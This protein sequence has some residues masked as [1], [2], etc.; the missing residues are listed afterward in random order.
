MTLLR[1]GPQASAGLYAFER[2][3]VTHEA[4]STR[5]RGSVG[6]RWYM[7]PATRSSV[8]VMGRDN[9]LRSFAIVSTRAARVVRPCSKRGFVGLAEKMLEFCPELG[10]SSSVI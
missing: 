6:F 8:S 3:G 5:S 7:F 1:I 9:S 2:V 4:S 10:M